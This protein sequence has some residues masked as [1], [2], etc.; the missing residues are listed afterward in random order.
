MRKDSIMASRPKRLRKTNWLDYAAKQLT[1]RLKNVTSNYINGRQTGFVFD[2]D[3]SRLLGS[4][5][6]NSFRKTTFPSK[7][8]TLCNWVRASRLRIVP[9]GRWSNR[10]TV[11]KTRKT[12]YAR[13]LTE[14]STAVAASGAL[15]SANWAHLVPQHE[16][17]RLI[18]IDPD[19]K[20][21]TWKLALLLIFRGDW[22]KCLGITSCAW[23]AVVVGGLSCDKWFG[24]N[25]SKTLRAF[26]KTWVEFERILEDLER[27]WED[28]DWIGILGSLFLRNWQLNRWRFLLLSTDTDAICV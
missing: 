10:E 14:K 8:P 1:A 11:L 12:F 7:P 13:D 15:G 24:L 23:R 26:E 20:N 25:W 17:L 22:N 16:R 19:A 6:L 2:S 21:L 28:L 5:R 3:R 4:A 27:F 9:L 18:G